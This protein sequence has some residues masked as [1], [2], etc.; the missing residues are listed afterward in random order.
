MLDRRGAWGCKVIKR[1]RLPTYIATGIVIKPQPRLP[2]QRE[3]Y[4]V[5]I[6]VCRVCDGLRRHAQGKGRIDLISLATKKPGRLSSTPF[7]LSSYLKEPDGII[8]ALAKEVSPAP[9]VVL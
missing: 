6:E 5:A 7:I 3:G 8:N 4:L 9:L 1:R 2:V